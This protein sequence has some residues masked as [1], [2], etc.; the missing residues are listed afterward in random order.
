MSLT[1]SQR[2]K[3]GYDPAKVS[4]FG[5][6]EAPKGPPG[7]RGRGTYCGVGNPLAVLGVENSCELVLVAFFFSFPKQRVTILPKFHC[8]EQM[9]L[10]RLPNQELVAKVC[11][12]GEIFLGS[13]RL[14]HSLSQP[15]CL[16]YRAVA[17]AS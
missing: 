8:L 6:D 12:V 4:L 14:R 2:G 7:N 11:C 3:E 1:D 5:T 9:N 13:V 10:P 15:F 17:V 16:R